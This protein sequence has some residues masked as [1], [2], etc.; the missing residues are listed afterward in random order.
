MAKKRK[1]HR[2]RIQ[3]QGGDNDLESSQSWSQEEPLNKEDGLRLLEELK[4]QIPEE[5]ANKRKY[6]FKKVQEFIEEAAEN[7]GVDSSIRNISFLE[8]GTK[9]TRVDIEVKSGIAFI[10]LASLILIIFIV[11]AI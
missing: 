6:A 7:G 11:W 2:G 4:N 8:P 10:I 3:A 9:D 5:E 1:K